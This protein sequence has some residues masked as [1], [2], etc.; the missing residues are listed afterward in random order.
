MANFYIDQGS[1]F[2]SII[3]LTNADGTAR[4]LTG[5]AIAAQIRRGFESTNAVSFTSTIYSAVAGQIKLALTNTQTS[6]MKSG[7]WVFDVELTSSVGTKSKALK[8]L[9]IIDPEVTR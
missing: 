6:A 7:R 5:Y 3:T 9:V 2:S 4:D 8:G 1:D